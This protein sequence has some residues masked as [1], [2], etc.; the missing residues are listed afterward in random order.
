M[1]SIETKP[2]PAP[3]GR[4]RGFDRKAAL[5]QAMHVFWTLGYEGAS[6]TALQ[7][8]MG[9]ITAPSFYAAFGSKER[10]FREAVELYSSTLGRPM[11]DALASEPSV[12]TALE[13]LLKA[14]AAAFTKPGKPRGCM[15]V[16]SAINVTPANRAIQDHLRSLRARRRKLI[17]ER[18]Q[19]AAAEGELP[20]GA[21]WKE[22]ASFF[23]TVID[24]LAIQARD[25]ASRRTL[26]LTA[27]CAMAAWDRMVVSQSQ[28]PN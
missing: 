28:L 8:A 18:L 7:Q 25:G 19:R 23:T 13:A 22:L 17:R 1:D 2:Q 4:P 6:L 24:G 3:R 15:L 26:Q 14:A 5:L 9:G 21:D 27:R 16:F 20:S 10:L 12:R 11:M